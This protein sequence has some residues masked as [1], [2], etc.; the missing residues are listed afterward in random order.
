MSPLLHHS[1]PYIADPDSP[2]VCLCRSSSLSHYEVKANS[3]LE[4]YH[5][6]GPPFICVFKV[7]PEES[8]VPREGDR[9]LRSSH[10]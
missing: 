5:G 6:M 1:C 7:S 8:K 2:V 3:S 10:I 4:R 9:K